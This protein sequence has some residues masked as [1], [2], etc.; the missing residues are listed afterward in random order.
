MIK[1][2]WLKKCED[3]EK[4]EYGDLREKKGFWGNILKYYTEDEY[5]NLKIEFKK[6][7]YRYY[8]HAFYELA[9]QIAD[10]TIFKERGKNKAEDDYE[11]D[12]ELFK[13]F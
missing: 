3:F 7:K 13:F 5:N 10:L 6:A 9:P 2:G 12:E 11:Y 4:Y 8:K 1:N